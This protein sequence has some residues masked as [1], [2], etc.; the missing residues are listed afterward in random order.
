M[1]LGPNLELRLIRKINR[2]DLRN[3]DIY[4]CA[5]VFDVT[6]LAKPSIAQNVQFQLK[7]EFQGKEFNHFSMILFFKNK[8]NFSDVEKIIMQLKWI[9]HPNP[10]LKP[11]AEVCQYPADHPIAFESEHFCDKSKKQNQ[12]CIACLGMKKARSF[13]NKTYAAQHADCDTK[14]SSGEILNFLFFIIFSQ[15]TD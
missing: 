1:I 11:L 13:I 8:R 5:T 9:Q 2:W 15:K 6:M 3:P 10:R 14:E 7:S 4:S 12:V